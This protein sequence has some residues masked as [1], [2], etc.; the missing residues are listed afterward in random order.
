MKNL[1][2]VERARNDMSQAAL[3]EKVHVTRQTVHT[4]DK[5]G[6]VLSTAL[7]FKIASIFKFFNTIMFDNSMPD[8]MMRKPSDNTKLKSL[9]PD[10]SYTS[11]GDGLEETIQW[12]TDNYDKGN[13]RL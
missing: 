1:I 3:A 13:V 7:A 5:G 4:I 2:K 12:F 9:L 8:G 11:I 10:F 6:I